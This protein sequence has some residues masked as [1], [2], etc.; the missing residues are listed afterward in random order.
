VFSGGF[1]WGQVSASAVL[2]F[3]IV[4]V[5]TGRLVPRSA[6]K[7]AERVRDEWRQ[8]FK[9]SQGNVTEL[10]RQQSDLL[11]IGKSSE[12]MLREIVD[13]NRQQRQVNFSLQQRLDGGT[14]STPDQVS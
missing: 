3:A 12:T 9:D 13:A 8:M 4:L 1:P 14:S 7:D 6:L 5:L 11:I 2:F 10:V